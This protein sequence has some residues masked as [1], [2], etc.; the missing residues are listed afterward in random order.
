MKKVKIKRD[1]ATIWYEKDVKGYSS[2]VDDYGTR[3]NINEK[4]ST[5][6]SSSPAFS[7]S[8]TV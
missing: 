5:I 6:T 8:T 2:A 1:I 4:L 3:K 7:N